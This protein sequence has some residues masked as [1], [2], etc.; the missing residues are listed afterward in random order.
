MSYRVFPYVRRPTPIMEKKSW[1]SIAL[2][3]PKASG[4]KKRRYPTANPMKNQL[5]AELTV[6]MLKHIQS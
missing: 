2:R 3:L 5:A 6:S 1:K 4:V